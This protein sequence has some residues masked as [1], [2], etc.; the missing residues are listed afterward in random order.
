MD[1][2]MVRWNDEWMDGWMEWWMDSRMSDGA[3]RNETSKEIGR[4]WIPNTMG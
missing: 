1:E 2:R 4:G 3:L